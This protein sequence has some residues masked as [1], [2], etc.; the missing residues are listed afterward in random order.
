NIGAVAAGA[1]RRARD[2]HDLSPPARARAGARPADLA[3]EAGTARGRARH[4]RHRHH[5]RGAFARARGLQ[6]R[7]RPVTARAP[8]RRGAP[9]LGA[10]AY[11]RAHD[12]R[13]RAPLRSGACRARRRAARA[14][15]SPAARSVRAR[16]AAPATFRN[17]D[18]RIVLNGEE[19]TLPRPMTVQ[20]LLEHLEIDP[21]LVAVEC[22]RVVVRRAKYAETPI[23]PDAEVEIVAFVGG[24]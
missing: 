14:A 21:R 18:M 1:G 24:G 12:R 15:P 23:P 19:T 10:R 5:R 2:G 11:R 22:N 4:G 16:R 13:L 7:R 20:E 3:S 9:L 6:A 8:R 17:L